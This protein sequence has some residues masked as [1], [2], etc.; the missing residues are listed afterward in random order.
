[1]SKHQLITNMTL[2]CFRFVDRY[3]PGY[4]FFG[5]GP[6]RGSGD[7]DNYNEKLPWKGKGVRVFLDEE[8]LPIR[9]EYF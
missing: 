1:V 8:R 7:L 4:I 2:S 9:T 5:E 3:I 6:T